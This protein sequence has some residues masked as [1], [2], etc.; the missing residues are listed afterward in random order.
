MLL[1]WAI[2]A[3]KW[4][5]AMQ[6]VTDISFKNSFKAIFSGNALAFFTPNRIGEY[7]GRMLHLEE[8]KRIISIPL[9]MVCS[10]AQL[11]ITLI[12]GCLGLVFLSGAIE[13]HFA[14]HSN[15]KFW[16]SSVLYGTGA[17]A[18]V[19][20]IF[21]F[22]LASLVKRLERMSW[23]LRW[24]EQLSI[25]GG[26]NATILFRILSLSGARYLVFIVQYYLLFR[27]FGVEVDWWQ[28]FWSVSVVFV[29]IAIVPGMGFLS[30]LGVRWQASI[31]LLQIFSPNIA[32]IFATSLVVWM[33]N[34]VIPAI[35]GGILILGMKLFRK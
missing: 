10:I 35:I 25:L 8:K 26:I 7:F 18:I 19:L 33:I 3:M 14:S 12:V 27:V 32:G 11:L 17:V 2:E 30:E 1:N 29:I 6:T 4:Q 15:I 34:Q 16:L 21:Y 13:N 22:R 31:R 9:T 20:T 23:M 28:A 5:S 24:K